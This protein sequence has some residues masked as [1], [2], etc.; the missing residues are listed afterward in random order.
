VEN[1]CNELTLKSDV[2]GMSHS[3][4]GEEVDDNVFA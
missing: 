4:A 1:N 2:N 3:A